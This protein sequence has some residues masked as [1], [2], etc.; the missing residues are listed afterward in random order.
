MTRETFAGLLAPNLP[1]IRRLVQS[2][3]RTRDEADDVL[4]QTLLY[5]FARRD[6]LRAPDKFRNWLWT[7]ALNEVRMLLR[8][9]RPF[10]WIDEFPNFELP[11]QT[12]SPHAMCEQGERVQRLH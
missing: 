3:V 2:R 10:V 6:Q 11:D 7:I 5:A 1:S 12:P 8:R 4:Q 9:A